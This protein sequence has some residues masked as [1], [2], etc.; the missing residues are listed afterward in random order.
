[1]DRV[2]A[3]TCDELN[4]QI[5]KREGV[6]VLDCRENQETEEGVLPGAVL[7]TRGME[8]RGGAIRALRGASVHL[9]G[10]EITQCKTNVSAA[11]RRHP[12][13][14]RSPGCHASRASAP[15]APLSVVVPGARCCA[16]TQL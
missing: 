6:I 4:E 1:M 13:T 8:G 5:K 9:F 15:G 16:G 14:C 12:R 2:P 3:K 7:L 10:C 11:L